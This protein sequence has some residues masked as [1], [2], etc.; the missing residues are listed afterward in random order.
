[1]QERIR[2]RKR[3]VNLSIDSALIDEAKAA[4]LK[5]SEL[6]ETTLRERLRD[7]R[8]K[9]WRAE[10]RAAVESMNRYVAGNGLLSDRYK[11]R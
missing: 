8:W 2:S 3:A 9:E 10:N 11:V 4:G 6:L 1:M 7:H 5:L